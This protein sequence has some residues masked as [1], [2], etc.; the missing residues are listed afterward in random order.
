MGQKIQN[1]PSTCEALSS[2]PST[3]KKQNKTMGVECGSSGRGPAWQA[4]SSEFKRQLIPTK[5]K[6]DKKDKK[7]FSW[8]PEIICFK[9]WYL[10]CVMKFLSWNSSWLELEYQKESP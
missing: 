3:T 1:L 10:I 2:I 9:I 8:T 5:T 4:Q 7:Q 6:Q